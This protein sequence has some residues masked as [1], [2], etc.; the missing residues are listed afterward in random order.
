MKRAKPRRSLRG[1]RRP[2]SSLRRRR[3]ARRRG[4]QPSSAVRSSPQGRFRRASP[5]PSRPTQRRGGRDRPAGGVGVSSTVR[6]AARKSAGSSS[7]SSVRAPAAPT[8]SARPTGRGSSATRPSCEADDGTKSAARPWS[9]RAAAVASPIAAIRGSLP[10]PPPRELDGAVRTRDDDPVVAVEVDRA[11]VD[12]LDLDQRAEHRLEAFDAQRGEE[13]FRLRARASDDHAH[14]RRRRTASARPRLRRDRNRSA[15]RASCRPRLRRDAVKR[16]P[17]WYAATGARQPPPITATQARS[18]STRRP[19][20]AVVCS[21]D[22]VLLAGAHLQCERALPG[23][24]QEL[25]GLEPMTDLGSEPEPVE[26]AGREHDRIQPALPALAQTRL[27]V[28]AQR[29]DR[30]RRLE[31]EQLRA[32]AN[33]GCPDPHPGPNASRRRTAR[34]EDPRARGTHRRPARRCRS[35]S[36]PLRSALRRR[37]VRRGVPPRAP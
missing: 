16:S 28:P 24:R 2:V 20:L 9:A 15:A 25:V 33:R 10:R 26:T 7:A 1:P 18:I 12:G 37:C 27:D 35:R 36:C 23:L 4:R 11:V 29:L 6:Y 21:R 30:E 31:R 17:S 19:R 32:P 14:V 5:R 13:W 34:R 3:R 8:K 22:E